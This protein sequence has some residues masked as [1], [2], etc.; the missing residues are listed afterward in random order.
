[1]KTILILGG[2]QFIGR[3]LIEK[4]QATR[5]YELTLFNRQQTN[6]HLF[7]DIQKIK[8]DRETADVEQLS[9]Q[10][11]DY[12]IDLS[13]YLPAT[14]SSVIEQLKT[15]PKKYIFIS[16]CSV[17]DNSNNKH[18]L[19]DE[20][21]DIHSCTEEQS[22]EPTLKYYGNKKAECERILSASGFNHAILRPA[23]VVGPYDHTDRFYYWSHQVKENNLLLMPDNGESEFS[24]TYVNDL[25][26]AIITLL[27][28]ETPSKVFNII[29]YQQLSIKKIVDTA[30][31]ILDKQPDRIN[32]SPAFLKE[33]EIKQW[34]DMPIWIDG[35]FFTYSN[36]RMRSEIGIS[37]TAFEDCVKN[38]IDYYQKLKWPIPTYGITEKKRQEL[39]ELLN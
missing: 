6:T 32:A 25:V 9:H 37:P 8:G 1:M 19:R 2:T 36:D 28:Q 16:T 30:C 23:L 11:W 3:N 22:K 35:N 15:A 24:V 26:D 18:R 31:A 13:C 10:Q 29:S 4:L 17:Y 5:K 39:I 20:T 34:L 27:E 7:S 38:T 14:L 12:V 33:Q 21:A